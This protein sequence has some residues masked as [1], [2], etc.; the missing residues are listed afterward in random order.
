MTTQKAEQNKP[1][2][3][4]LVLEPFRRSNSSY[5]LVENSVSCDGVSKAIAALDEDLEFDGSAE[6]GL[7]Q[8][9]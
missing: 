9:S 2:F 1:S 5:T 6:I 7:F 4:I 3:Q 8:V